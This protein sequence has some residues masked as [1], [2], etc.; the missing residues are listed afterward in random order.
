MLVKRDYNLEGQEGSAIA[1]R[2]ATPRA[3]TR[4]RT[5]YQLTENNSVW[6]KPSS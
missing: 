4:K 1:R 6:P 2:Y 3:Q 5:M